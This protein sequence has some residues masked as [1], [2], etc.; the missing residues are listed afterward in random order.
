MAKNNKEQEDKSKVKL[1]KTKHGWF[2]ALTR[3]FKMFSFRTKKEVKPTNFQ[4]LDSLK[5]ANVSDSR[6]A[7]KK[8]AA[9]VATLLGIG[10]TGASNPTEAHAATTTVDQSSQVIGSGSGSTSTSTS[11]STSTSQSNTSTSESTASTSSVN[12]SST[13]TSTS[14]SGSSKSTS[15][16]NVSTST[17]TT[18]T[19]TSQSNASTSESTTS[20]SVSSSTASTT[21][22][23]SVSTWMNESLTSDNT[24]LSPENGIESVVNEA[25]NNTA[26]SAN[27]SLSL[28]T[29]TE[30][31]TNGTIA[32]FNASF[33][34]TNATEENTAKV[35][36]GTE[37]KNALNNSD[38]SVIQLTADIDLGQSGM[39]DLQIPPRDLTIDGAGHSLNL[40]NNCI[41]LNNTTAGTKTT[42]TVKSLNLYTANERGGFALTSDGAETLIYDNVHATG[43]AAVM[44]DTFAPNGNL[45][46]FEIQGHTTIDGVSSYQYNG[47]TYSTSSANFVGY[48]TLMYAGNDLIIDDNASLVVNN[49]MSPYD[50]AM[51]ANNGEHAVKVGE[52]ATLT[53]NNT[54]NYSGGQIWNNVGNIALTNQDGKFIAGANSHINLSTSGTNVYF[55]NGC[56]NNTVSF[57][58]GTNTTFSGNRNFYFGGSGNTVNINDPAHVILNTTTGTTYSSNSSNVTINANNTNVIVTNDGITTASNYFGNNQSTVNGTSYTIGVTTGEQ[59]NGNAPVQTVMADINQNG[60]TRLEYTSETEHSESISHSESVSGSTSTSIKDSVSNSTSRSLSTSLSQSES[61]SASLS[62]S[63]ST[64]L[65][66]SGSASTSLSQSE[67]ASTSLSQSESTST[68]LSESASTSLSQSE[69]A[70]TS[71]SQSES[72]STS[73]SESASTSLSQSESASTSLS[74]SESASTSLSQSESASTSL[75][76]SESASTSLSQSESASTSLSQSESTSTSLSESAS[77]SL[78]QSESASTSLSQSESASTSLSQSE[79]TSISLSESASTSLSQSESASTSLSQSESASTSLSQ[80]ESASTS[81]SQSESASTSLS[82]SESTSTSLSESAST[83]LSQSESASTSLSQSES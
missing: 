9:T 11:G 21:G 59:D 43:G 20:N 64:S 30:N 4:D 75:S 29:T 46:T 53:I 41:W 15:E 47:N 68:S 39:G 22:A 52:N 40:G 65:S 32:L 71:L 28:R 35:S 74:Q 23:Q 67:S 55:A 69:S 63:A 73:L 77:T 33:I 83:S 62:Q 19:S 82:Q 57:E 3:F 60:T 31:I 2:S 45:K 76:Q 80:S 37:F 5:N 27:Q 10:A 66:Q 48:G 14:I 7:Y 56:D 72:T 58:Q 44:A 16:S 8:G 78:S 34:Q 1:Y 50:V 81:L 42:T 6:D 38:I 24:F 49:S 54:Y 25:S 79:S 70:S 36:N 13:S 26:F 18:S 17:S 12:S 61:F 51:L